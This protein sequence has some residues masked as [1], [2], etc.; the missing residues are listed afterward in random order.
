MHYSNLHVSVLPAY[1][2]QYEKKNAADIQCFADAGEWMRKG[3]HGFW[4]MW[5]LQFCVKAMNYRRAAV[6][7]RVEQ[8][9]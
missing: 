3:V 7:Q 8:V 2:I 5:S 9:D 4:K 1:N 6:A